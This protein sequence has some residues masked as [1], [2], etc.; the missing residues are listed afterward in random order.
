MTARTLEFWYDFASPYAYLACRRIEAEAGEA[1][2]EIAWRPFLLGPIFAAARADGRPFQPVGPTE[3]AYR[4][5]D[6][7][8]TS[9]KSPF[10][11]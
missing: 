6:I 5:R 7:A 4:W 9:S 3:R 8:R 1:G 11:R 2:L 10:M